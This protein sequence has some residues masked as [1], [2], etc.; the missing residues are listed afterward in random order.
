MISALKVSF[1]LA[2]IQ[3]P[4][5]FG[6]SAVVAFWVMETHKNNNHIKKCTMRVGGV[7]GINVGKENT[8]LSLEFFNTYFIRQGSS[9]LG[10]WNTSMRRPTSKQVR[11]CFPNSAADPAS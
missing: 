9:Y 4:V 1:S 6:L 7:V 10:V 2:S 8:V 3:K 5:K 11:P